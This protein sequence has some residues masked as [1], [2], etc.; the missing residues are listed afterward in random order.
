MRPAALVLALAALF[1]LGGAGGAGASGSGEADAVRAVKEE[2]GNRW[3]LME[4]VPRALRSRGA[5]ASVDCDGVTG[6]R[7]LCSW[8]ARNE[9]HDQ[10]AEGFAVVVPGPG[11][12]ADARLFASFCAAHE[13]QPCV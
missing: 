6:A 4:T 8:S 11:D 1:A 12:V 2:I 7:F 5:S 10:V 13:A 9:F 3:L